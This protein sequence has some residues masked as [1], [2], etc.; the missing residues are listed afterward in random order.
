[1]ATS[2]LIFF[3]P[4]QS[5]VASSDKLPSQTFTVSLSF[6]KPNVIFLEG[7]NSD[8]IIKTALDIHSQTD[9][10][11]FMQMTEEH[12]NIFKSQSKLKQLDSLTIFYPEI[13]D[14]NY[15]SQK[16]VHTLIQS[17]S[18]DVLIIFSS[19]LSYEDLNKK[20]LMFFDLLKGKNTRHIKVYKHMVQVIR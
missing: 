1:M 19:K 17:S 13:S 3:P 14:L 16:T 18:A 4:Q 8:T 12:C 9:H 7:S 11:G 5:A 6:T 15:A 10:V 2:N 20:N